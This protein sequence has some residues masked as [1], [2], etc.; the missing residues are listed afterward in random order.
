MATGQLELETIVERLTRVEQEVTEIRHCLPQRQADPSP[1]YLKHAG[2]FKQ[3]PDF[4]EIVRLGAEIR[5]A[6]RPQ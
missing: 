2:K 6:D 5:D 1:W 3:D 4:Q